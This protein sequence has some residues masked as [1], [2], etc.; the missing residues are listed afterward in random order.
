M[1][2][3]T[4]DERDA[5]AAPGTA[6]RYALDTRQVPWPKVEQARFEP[7][8]LICRVGKCDQPAQP[9]HTPCCTAH[10]ATAGDQSAAF[11]CEHYCNLHFVEVS[12]CSPETHLAVAS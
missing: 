3:M 12:R 9:E 8:V 1:S 4:P 6:F 5:Y 7:E 11:C 10:A 2:M